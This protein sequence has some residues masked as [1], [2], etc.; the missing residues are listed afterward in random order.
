LVKK[1]KYGLSGSIV[2]RLQMNSQGGTLRGLEAPAEIVGAD[3]GREVASELIVAAIVVTLD[4]RALDG[5]VHPLDLT[6]G[7]PMLGFGQ[8][9]LDAELRAGVLESMSPD[10]LSLHRRLND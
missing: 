3:E 4:G 5:A 8:A 2:H 6:V 7:P 10:G 9:M 1:I